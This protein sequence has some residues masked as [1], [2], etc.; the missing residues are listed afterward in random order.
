MESRDR[1]VKLL[2][3][4]SGRDEPGS[5]KEP[6]DPPV[7]PAARAEIDAAESTWD[8]WLLALARLQERE[9][10]RPN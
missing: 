2:R 9:E 8:P 3:R 4:D 6:F 10:R 7:E 1:E 5:S